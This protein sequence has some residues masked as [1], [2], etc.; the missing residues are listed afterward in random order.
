M[1]ANIVL[2]E[3]LRCLN[4]LHN[5]SKFDLTDSPKSYVENVKKLCDEA[6]RL[7]DPK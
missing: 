5:G 3:L 7:I 6:K 4:N 1:N 2:R